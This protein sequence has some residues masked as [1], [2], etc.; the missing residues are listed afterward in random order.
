[1]RLG[2]SSPY[3]SRSADD[4]DLRREDHGSAASPWWPS[5]Y[6]STFCCM[7]RGQFLVT[8]YLR[9]ISI[10]LDYSREF[11]PD[12]ATESSPGNYLKIDVVVW[13][14]AMSLR[15][16]LKLLYLVDYRCWCYHMELNAY[17]QW[18]YHDEIPNLIKGDRKHWA[19]FTRPTKKKKPTKGGVTV[20]TYWLN[21]ICLGFHIY[22]IQNLR[23]SSSVL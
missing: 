22:T 13:T 1:M 20:Q 5:V 21:S 7:V 10:I 23:N 3:L 9:Y 16:G 14:R 12:D 17:P 2:N 15:S 18:C 6:Y 19:C 4:L 11:S 8:F